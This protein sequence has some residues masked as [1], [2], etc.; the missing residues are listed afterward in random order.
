MDFKLILQIFQILLALAFV[1]SLSYRVLRMTKKLTDGNARYMKIIEKT[2]LGKDSYL[3]VMKIGEEYELVS[4]TAGNIVMVREIP[5]EEIEKI[6]QDKEDM[7]TNNPIATY[8]KKNASPNLTA[9]LQKVK[10]RKPRE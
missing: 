8:F 7:I 5:K 2:P 1:L 4:V 9:L 6:L 10:T 3:A